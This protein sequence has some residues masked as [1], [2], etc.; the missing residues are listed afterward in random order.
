[1]KKYK[2]EDWL[3]EQYVEK[4][5]LQRNIANECRVDPST[6]S[7]WVN[8]HGVQKET[9]YKNKDW[10]KEQYGIRGRSQRDIA[11]ECKVGYRTVGNWIN[12]YGIEKK[13]KEELAREETLNWSEDIAYLVGLITADGCLQRNK[14]R[15][16]FYSKDYS[17]IKQVREIVENN[18]DINECEPCRRNRNKTISWQYQFTSRKFYYFLENIGLMPNKSLKLSVLDVPNNMFLD[19]LRG[20]IDGD[21]CFYIRTGRNLLQLAITS[22]SKRFLEWV[23]R[24]LKNRDLVK[25]EGNV[26]SVKVNTYQLGFANQDSKSIAEAIYNNADYY[27]RRKYDIVEGFIN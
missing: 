8:K 24:E 6:I 19:W 22:G 26:R 17:L 9:K 10:L 18:L 3:K 1:M 15:I 14:P 2:D 20:E 5:R 16:C 25:G 13:T 27:L 23:S 21:G 4:D 7:R 11:R 12:K